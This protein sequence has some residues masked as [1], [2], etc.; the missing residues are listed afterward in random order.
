MGH[1]ERD[2]CDRGDASGGRWTRALADL[3]LTDRSAPQ[4]ADLVNVDWPSEH[5]YKHAKSNVEKYQRQDFHYAIRPDE[6]WLYQVRSM[7]E[8]MLWIVRALVAYLFCYTIILFRDNLDT[9]FH[10]LFGPEW[11]PA[12]NKLRFLLFGIVFAPL[13]A[14]AV[15]LF[16]LKITTPPQL[17]QILLRRGSV[18]PYHLAVHIRRGI[19]RA[20]INWP[21]DLFMQVVANVIFWRRLIGWPPMDMNALPPVWPDEFHSVRTVWPG[22]GQIQFGCGNKGFSISHHGGYLYIVDWEKVW[23]MYESDTGYAGADGE[24]SV[25]PIGENDWAPR[26][27]RIRLRRVTPTT[28][29]PWLVDSFDEIVIPKRFFDSAEKAQ[30]FLDHCRHKWTEAQEERGGTSGKSAGEIHT[31]P[32]PHGSGRGDGHTGSKPVRVIPLR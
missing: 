12:F 28:L 13:G 11:W 30:E 5:E 29:P 20:W 8:W 32:E 25:L 19:S 16:F 4:Y 22:G 10:R 24:P 26:S 3:P 18:H 23:F 7:P 2:R 6:D 9:E 14:S 27:L 31:H 15:I 17:V 21:R 1:Q